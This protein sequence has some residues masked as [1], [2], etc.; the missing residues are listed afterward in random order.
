MLEMFPFTPKHGVETGHEKHLCSRPY[1]FAS[2]I[3]II[4]VKTELYSNPTILGFKNPIILSFF[5]PTF[6]E[7]DQ[8][9]FGIFT[10][11][12]PFRRKE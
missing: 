9:D 1:H 2:D 4:E 8:M 3:H 11:Y 6:S 5:K 7:M 10:N 12:S